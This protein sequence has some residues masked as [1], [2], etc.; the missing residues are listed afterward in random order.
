MFKNSMKWFCPV[1]IILVAL[2]MISCDKDPNEPEPVDN[3]QWLRVGGSKVPGIFDIEIIGDQEAFIAGKEGF[4]AHTVNQ[5]ADWDTIPLA[6][7]WQDLF[8]IDRIP[9]GVIWAC[10][11]KGL[12][13]KSED[14][15]DSWTDI[16]ADDFIFIDSTIVDSVIIDSVDFSDPDNILQFTRDTTLYF[17]DTVEVQFRYQDLNDVEFSDPQQGFIASSGGVVYVTSDGGVSWEGRHALD[18]TI[19]IP[20]PWYKTF[21]ETLIVGTDTTIIDTVLGDT[22]YYTQKTIFSTNFLGACTYGNSKWWISGLDKSIL[23]SGNQG[24]N[25]V[26]KLEPES[27]IR[28]EDINFTSATD[29]WAVGSECLILKTLDG[30]E[31]W[32]EVNVSSCIRDLLEI[33]FHEALQNGWIVGK[34]SKVLFTTNGGS[35]WSNDDSE[36]NADLYSTGIIDLDTR[37]IVGYRTS[38]RVGTILLT[39]DNGTEWT[40]QSYGVNRYLS[41][42]CFTDVN[43]GWIVGSDG[44]CVNTT[45][46]GNIWVHQNSRATSYLN[47]IHMR[48]NNLGWLVGN[49]GVIRKTTDGGENWNTVSS[50]VQVRLH[51]VY[52]PTNNIGYAVGDSGTILKSEDG[53]DSWEV[54]VYPSKVHFK[55][56]YFADPNNGWLCGDNGT[57]IHTTDGAESWEQQDCGTIAN[58]LGLHFISA[59]QGWVV[60]SMEGGTSHIYSTQDGGDTWTF[61]N[62]GESI[63]WTD[64]FFTDANNG[65]VT[66]LYG[67]IYHTNDGGA[68]WHRQNSENTGHLSEISFINSDP[69]YGFIVGE[70]GAILRYYPEE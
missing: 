66:G 48:D 15:G 53:G 30:G 11:Q 19:V 10:G 47:S 25:W 51:K 1:T 68:N 8:D 20:I 16:S 35:S 59:N 55:D 21:V 36:V 40:I 43:N 49:D 26:R 38:A 62:T 50:G 39:K 33:R 46:G 41:G 12:L 17:L 63:W 23:Y 52:F 5:G 70:A 32:N 31:S 2:L 9:G 18:T 3:S 65:W 57:V 61:Q 44:V 58:F 14:G 69:D 7:I 27:D 22:T 13:L 29:G 56:L 67:M 60:G 6:G 28:L 64:V 37:W 34:T 42:L 45:D 24:Q 54:Q 4:I